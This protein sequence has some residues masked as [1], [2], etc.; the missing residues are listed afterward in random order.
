[1]VAYRASGRYLVQFGG[2]FAHPTGY[3][4]LL[5]R[6]TEFAAARRMRVVA[7]QLQRADA[8][9]YADAGF[10]V[11][12]VGA[13]YAV[14]L[15]AFTVRG[16][17]FVRLRNKISRAF[18][19]GLAVHEAD[20]AGW[21]GAMAEL[22]AKWLRGKGKHAKPLEFLVG[23]YG[24]PVQRHRRLFVGLLDGRLAGYISY[25]PVP[26]SRPG[27]L[28]DLSRR[29]PDGPPGIMEAINKTAIDTFIAEG[30]PWL[31]FGF[32]PFTGLSADLEPATASAWF[33]WLVGQLGRR[34]A[35]VYPA[36]TQL[37]YKD[38]WAPHAV[39]P[40]YIAFSSRASLGAF[41]RVFKVANAL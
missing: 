26:G 20:A 16:S 3:G 6:F 28:H 18:R 41:L 31:H 5:T 7:I 22:D 10:V 8:E 40:E 21:L 1:V 19:S 14:D 9:K 27:W 29:L 36:R 15:S 35:A 17:A 13:S 24:G 39:L 4:E 23:E 12:Q 25:S 34:G 32:T 11:N 33:R 30:V 38:K 2:P 37:A